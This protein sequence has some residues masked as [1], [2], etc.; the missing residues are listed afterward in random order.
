MVQIWKTAIPQGTW[1]MFTCWAYTY[2]ISSTVYQDL[3]FK[4]SLITSSSRKEWMCI[5]CTIKCN[6]F[7]WG[8]YAWSLK[9][10]AGFYIFNQYVHPSLYEI[11]PWDCLWQNLCTKLACYYYSHWHHFLWKLRLQKWNK[12]SKGIKMTPRQYAAFLS[13]STYFQNCSIRLYHSITI[14]LK[15]QSNDAG[16]KNT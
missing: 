6:E 11:Q 1:N 15:K 2:S 14:T 9:F 4:Q 3:W 12:L 10:L 8:L 13:Q 7:W 16:I 5:Q